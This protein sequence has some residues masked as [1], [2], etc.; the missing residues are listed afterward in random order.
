[1]ETASRQVGEALHERMRVVGVGVA[2]G[3]D[4]RQAAGSP[5]T[6]KELQQP[7]R[8]L[9]RPVQIVEH[10][11]E[12]RDLRGGGEH[13]DHGVEQP[14]P[15]SIVKVVRRRCL[16]EEAPELL[17]VAVELPPQV[18]SIARGDEGTDK[19]SPGPV[20]G[21]ALALPATRP[22][23]GRRHSRRDLPDQ[24]RL[25]DAGLAADEGHD[26]LSELR[27][28]YGGDQGMKLRLPT[29][30]RCRH[31]GAQ[32]GTSPARPVLRIRRHPSILPSSPPDGGDPAGRARRAPSTTPAASALGF[33]T[34]YYYVVRSYMHPWRN[35]DFRRG[36]PSTSPLCRR[37]PCSGGCRERRAARARKWLVRMAVGCG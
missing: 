21:R 15:R 5:I 26:A 28:L 22:Q 31:G 19:L 23:H 34:S 20:G 3:A 14:E 27:R 4:D 16:P 17:A 9:V 7:E 6:R 29:D 10:E 37:P 32:G 11:H 1:M 18:V 2:I 35:A 24:P 25:A 33:G 36:A 30:E 12:R 8:R 13:V